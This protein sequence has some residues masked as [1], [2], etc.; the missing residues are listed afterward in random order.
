MLYV[1]F[2]EKGI[3]N[4]VFFVCKGHLNIL[5]LIY[6]WIYTDNI[7]ELKFKNVNCGYTKLLGI[8]CE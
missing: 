2:G 6:V 4:F 5:K 7:L 3:N 1:Y 8:I